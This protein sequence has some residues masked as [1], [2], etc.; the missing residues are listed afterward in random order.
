MAL[1]TAS[2]KN[3]ALSGPAGIQT[4]ISF[5]PYNMAK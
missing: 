4:H 2:G 1:L 5:S 3:V